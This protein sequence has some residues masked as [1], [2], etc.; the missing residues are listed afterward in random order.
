MGK[1]M[2]ALPRTMLIT[3]WAKAKETGMKRPLLKDPKAVK[4]MKAIDY[5]FSTFEG[6]WKSQ[7]GVAIRSMI[8]DRETKRFL[9]NYPN[10]TVVELGAGLS[11]RMERLGK[12][13]AWWY[14]LDLPEGIETRRR[15]F[16]ETDS[17]RFIARSVFDFSWMDEVEIRNEPVLFIAEGLLMYFPEEKVRSLL[18]ELA[19]RFSK[20]EMLL[21]STAPCVVGKARW[22]DSLSKIDETPEFLWGPEDPGT[23]AS[24][25]RS[26]EVAGKWNFYDYGGSRWRWM[27]AFKY[28]PKLKRM[29]SCH[30]VRLR[31][32]PESTERRRN[33]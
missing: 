27:R 26:I 13:S 21:E 11:S 2:S 9:R 4:M 15:F 12:N 32:K 29:T 18:V 25:S 3:L 8:L 31:F 1:D 20:G 17:R 6:C 10:G 24:W 16:R 5:D 28:I 7:V 23:M 19:N 14:D 33:V 30:I 22:H